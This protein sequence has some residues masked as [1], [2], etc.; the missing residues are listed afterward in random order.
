MKLLIIIFGIIILG[1]FS[2]L[3]LFQSGFFEF[4][5]NTQVVRVFEMGKALS[6]G[7]F[8]VRWSQD[9][10]YGYGYPI[11]NFYSPL[12]YYIGGFFVLTGFDALLATKLMFIFGILF[13]GVSM[14]LFSNKFFGIKAGLVSSIIYMYFPYHAVNIYVR[15]AVGE[16]FAYAFLPLVFYGL[17]SLL[18]LEKAKKNYTKIIYTIVLI[19][20][21]IFLVA[22]SHNLSLFM[23][24]L[25]LL[26]FLVI[27][28]FIVNNKKQFLIISLSSIVLGLA[29]SSFYIIPAFLEMRYTNVA[30][31]IGGGADFK[32]H[33][34]C[35]NQYWNSMWGYGGSI[36]GCVDGLSFKL[37]K[38]NILLVFAAI[39]VFTPALYKKRFRLQEKTVLISFVLFVISIFF[40]LSI[41]EFLW[42]SV[43]YLAYVQYP[44]RFLNFVSLFISFIVGYL[45]FWL[46]DFST[47]KQKSGVII[48]GLIILLGLIFNQKLFTPQSFNS[49]PAE[50]YMQKNYISYTVSRISDEYMP[51]GFLKPQ[52]YSEI[53]KENSYL[54]KNG[55]LK[56]L[57]S[58]TNYQKIEF[59]LNSPSELFIN[60]AYF[61]AWRAYVNGEELEISQTN[62][63]MKVLLP[64]GKGIFEL[65]FVQTPLEVFGNLL[66]L[67]SFL[68]IIIGIIFIRI[69]YD[70]KQ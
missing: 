60:T 55:T 57:S 30:S 53:P 24:L 46:A 33:F 38:I 59:S 51:K 29:L 36:K 13:S 56:T 4:H 8:P 35:L 17:Y 41:S 64:Q 7:M 47:V 23:L 28:L 43:P 10:G 49:Y 19:A 16:F 66:S 27:S 42:Q 6:D 5:D 1:A 65:K 70:G 15:G 45:F 44:W 12:P 3:A 61:P 68:A 63:G 62:K 11:F 22:I 2:V 9:L 20:I 52:D 54:E 48:I 34:V 14:F 31:Q 39:A 67:S 26:V 58:K 40:T 69:K 21:G 37:G 50:Y 18:S 25:L 32:D